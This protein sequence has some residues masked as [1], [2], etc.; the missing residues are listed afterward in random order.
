MAKAVRVFCF[1]NPNCKIPVADMEMDHFM[2]KLRRG[3]YMFAWF[4]IRVSPHSAAAF[5]SAF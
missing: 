4:S 2:G 1:R 3:G 5:A